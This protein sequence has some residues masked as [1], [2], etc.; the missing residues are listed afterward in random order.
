MK[1]L[2]RKDLHCWSRFDEERNVDFNSVL[3]VRSEG[4]VLID[5]LPLSTH[6][7]R[8]CRAWVELSGL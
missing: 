5:P 8:S 1:L 3:W 6:D 7:K 2:H 4:N